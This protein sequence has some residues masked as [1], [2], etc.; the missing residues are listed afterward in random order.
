MLSTGFA[1][2]TPADS[3]PTTPVPM[4]IR[5]LVVDI[6]GTIAGRSNDVNDRVL[7]ALRQVQAQGI[8]VA[9]ATGRMYRSALRFHQRVQSKLPL[10]AY[11]GAWIQDPATDHQ[12]HHRPM[13][14]QHAAELLD[15]FEQPDLAPEISIHLYL[16]DQ[17]YVKALHDDTNDYSQRS[18][19]EAIAVTELR[20]LLDRAPTKLLAM[21]QNTDLIATTLADLKTRY[22][23]D[24]LYL[25]TSVATFLEAAHPSVN[26][27]AAVKYLAESVLGLQA[28]QVMAIGDNCNDIEMLEYVGL[29]VAMGKDAPSAL[30]AVAD[31]I[32]PNVDGDG[33]AVAIE[34][35]LL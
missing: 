2:L 31:W 16:D 20:D 29:G 13:S 24:Q 12:H 26:K 11:Q 34:K 8:P 28:S 30:L 5:L 9:L 21:S 17:L 22:Q 7:D 10:I 1:M 19:V 18:G 32:A 14:P 35:F 25:T 15:Y 6:D 3:M 27:G 23:P 33:V 4:D